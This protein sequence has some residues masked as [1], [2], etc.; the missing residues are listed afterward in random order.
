MDLKRW[1]LINDTT[2]IVVN[3]CDW[4]GNPETWQAP[5]GIITVEIPQD[6]WVGIDDLYNP[7]DGTFT[8]PD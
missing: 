7:A 2:N 4:D 8:R 3:V 1:A 5:A 6:S